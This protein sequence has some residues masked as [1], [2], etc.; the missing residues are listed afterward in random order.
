D[1]VGPGF[2]A[3]FRRLKPGRRVAVLHASGGTWA[4]E[5]VLSAR[6]VVPIPDDLP[7][8]QGAT[9]FVNPATVLVMVNKVLQVPRGSWL[10]QTAA[11]SALG[12]MIIR[13]GKHQGFRTLNV[14][15]R[16]EGADEL[17][18]LGADA[19]VV[20]A[21]DAQGQIRTIT[22]GTMVSYALDCVGGAMGLEAVKALGA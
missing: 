21:A 1:A 11:G 3:K 16:P 22:Q 12:R 4:E 10:L 17:K 15:R 13:L 9:F 18:R 8:D 6:N 19:V 20:A 14:I 7:D 2:L 5:V